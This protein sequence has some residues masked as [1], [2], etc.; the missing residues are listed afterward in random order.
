MY[1]LLLLRIHIGCKN[2]FILYCKEPTPTAEGGKFLES[3]MSLA[4]L[5]HTI[6]GRKL[7]IHF[8]GYDDFKPPQNWMLWT[9]EKVKLSD[10][11]I[12]VCSPSLHRQLSSRQCES[13]SMGTGCF[14]ST[15]IYNLIS[16]YPGKFIPCFIDIAPYHNQKPDDIWGRHYSDQIPTSLQSCTRYWL[17]VNELSSTMPDSEEV[18]DETEVHRSLEQAL[19]DRRYE[20]LGRLVC[21]LMGEPYNPRPTPSSSSLF[22]NT[23]P[24]AP[25]SLPQC[26]WC[27]SMVHCTCVKN[28]RFITYCKYMYVP[29]I[30]L[31]PSILTLN[32]QCLVYKL[33]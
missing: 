14:S 4:D 2:V 19:S 22:E 32:T 7:E 31:S 15:A 24:P 3:V 26:K 23:V 28:M 5:L 16:N 29:V 10:A 1:I 25:P 17:N 33:I 8:D 11:V 13:I 21:R 30:S 27:I 18:D 6:C 12:Y 20:G 9:E